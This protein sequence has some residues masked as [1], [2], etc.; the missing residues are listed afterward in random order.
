MTV[1]NRDDLLQLIGVAPLALVP[2]IGTNAEAKAARRRFRL[3][4]G[5]AAGTA[6]M[7]LVLVHLFY[8]PLDVIW[9]SYMQRFGL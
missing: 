7:A 9:Y 1:R 8:R 5:S 2:H 4:L 6:C 3:A